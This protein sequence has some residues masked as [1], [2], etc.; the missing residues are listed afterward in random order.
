MKWIFAIALLLTTTLSYAQRAT[1]L[2]NINVRAQE[3]KHKLNTK[4]DSIILRGRT[5]YRKGRNL[6]QQF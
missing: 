1:L 4:G 3:L 2:Q 5:H 6:Q